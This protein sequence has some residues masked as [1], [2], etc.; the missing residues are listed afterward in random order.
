MALLDFNAFERFP[1]ATFPTFTS[2]TWEYHVLVL[3]LLSPNPL[4]SPPIGRSNPR[5]AFSALHHLFLFS[6]FDDLFSCTP[7][8]G[9]S[10][11]ELKKKS[12]IL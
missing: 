12:S 3:A 6:I 4:I 11:E 5:S 2:K 10:D 9:G 8:L 1:S 7:S